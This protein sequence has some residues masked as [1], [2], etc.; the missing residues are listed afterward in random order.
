MYAIIRAG[1]KQYK[2][3][4]GDVIEI[5]RTKEDSDTVEFVPLLVV[6]DKGKTRSAKSD[7]A[8]ARVTATIVGETKG[9]KVN[10]AK[11]RNKTGYRRNAGHRQKY[12]SVQISGIKLTGARAASKTQ[13]EEETTDGT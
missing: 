2:V 10:V 5:E 4:E 11:Y 12:T 3:A 1:G 7:L 6:D 9:P 13:R 8:N